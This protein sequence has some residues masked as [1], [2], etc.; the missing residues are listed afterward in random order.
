M[1]K[2]ISTTTSL[3]GLALGLALLTALGASRAEAASPDNVSQLF[4]SRVQANDRFAAPFTTGDFD[5]DG[6]PDAV[7]LVT[8][9]PQ[10]AD[11]KLAADVTVISKLFGTEPL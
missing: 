6:T 4:G 9:L 2:L 8:I 5:G 3:G 1:K 11:H 10:S 7:Y